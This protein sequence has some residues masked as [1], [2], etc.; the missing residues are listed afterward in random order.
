MKL[1][2]ILCI[3]VVCVLLCSTVAFAADAIP[4]KIVEAREDVVSVEGKIAMGT[5][6]PIGKDDSGDYIVTN[7]HVVEDQQDSIQVVIGNDVKFDAEVVL[8]L[9]SS[10]LAVIKTT[11]V[12]NDST[13]FVLYDGDVDKLTGEVVYA[14]GFPDMADFLFNKAN[15]VAENS[16]ITNGIISAVKDTQMSE[17]SKTVQSLQMNVAITHGNSGGPLLNSHAEVVGI[18]SFGSDEAYTIN[19]AVSI[20]ELF[21]SL[22]KKKIPYTTSSQQT[23]KMITMIVIVIAAAVILTIVFLVLHKKRKNKA[24][25]SKKTKAAAK[26]NNVVTLEEYLTVHDGVVP[27]EMAE[28]MLAPVFKEAAQKHAMGISLINISTNSILVDK[29]QNRAFLTNQPTEKNSDYMALEQYKKNGQIGTW[30]DV[31]ALAAVL[32]RM[33]FGEAPTNLMD[34]IDDD[35]EVVQKVNEIFA[36]QAQKD[37]LMAALSLKIENRPHD[38]QIFADMIGIKDVDMTELNAYMIQEKNEEES[39]DIQKKPKKHW[40]KTKT[41]ILIVC[42]VVVAGIMIYVN[43][44]MGMV[45]IT[46]KAYA[47]LDAHRYGIVSQTISKAPHM[48]PALEEAKKIAEAGE[49]LDNGQFEEARAAFKALEDNPRVAAMEID[50]E[51]DYY[52]AMDLLTQ[53]KYEDAISAFE[54]LGDFKD[55]QEMITETKYRQ[56]EQM[57]IDEE[58]ASAYEI[59]TDLGDYMDS[60]EIKDEL[61]ELIYIVGVNAYSA[62]DYETARENF[63]LIPEY[64]DASKY[65]QWMQDDAGN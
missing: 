31:Y 54:A 2:R 61:M 47:Q 35:T 56:A 4:K 20:S 17:G 58:Y 63:E 42:A 6:F 64:E 44:N 55:S 48:T 52:I 24:D 32:Y 49:L 53:G 16:T 7:Y 22:D 50:K 1:R 57:E 59:Y 51:I 37:A 14:I 41:V 12:L 40:S 43:Y 39:P 19:G 25:D 46:N 9:P 60:I 26:N 15:T 8:E 33:M 23:A 10:D 5:G 36:E 21:N 3:L 34:R 13:P 29:V 11:E 27:F 38:A 28:Y 30:T 18:N 62:D 65:L 45:Y